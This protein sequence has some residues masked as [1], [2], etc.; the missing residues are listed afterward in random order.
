MRTPP[1]TF[2]QQ[3]AAFVFKAF[4]T[5]V[6]TLFVLLALT[7]GALVAGQS[8][9]APVSMRLLTS[10]GMEYAVATF[11]PYRHLFPEP[12]LIKLETE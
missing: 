5:L 7:V 12:Y 8:S 9:S 3:S 6:K 11:K 10:Y 2:A 4:F 1:Y